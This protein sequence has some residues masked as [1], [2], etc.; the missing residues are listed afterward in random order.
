MDKQLQKF[1]DERQELI[2]KVC[3]GI[4]DLEEDMKP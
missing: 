4:I 1:I 3:M 2:E